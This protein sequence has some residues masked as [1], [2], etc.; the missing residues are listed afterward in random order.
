MK[1]S[2]LLLI[3]CACVSCVLA[4][5]VF[6]EFRIIALFISAI[7]ATAALIMAIRLRKEA[8]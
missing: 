8:K 7:M 1:K 3:I 4:F 5:T 6:S 2:I